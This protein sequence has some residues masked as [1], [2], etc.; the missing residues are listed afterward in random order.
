MRFVDEQRSPFGRV[1]F[2]IMEASRIMEKFPMSSK[3]NNYP[4]MLEYLFDL[5]R[6]TCDAWLAQNG[7]A[8]GQRSTLD[9]QQLLHGGVWDHIAWVDPTTHGPRPRR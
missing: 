3:L 8:L 2:H 9:I 6:K 4:P 1:R 5:G 7:A